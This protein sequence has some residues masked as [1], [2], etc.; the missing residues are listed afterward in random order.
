MNTLET[1]RSTAEFMITVSSHHE[2][3]CLNTIIN[4]YFEIPAHLRTARSHSQHKSKVSE[5][6]TS[7]D[8][9]QTKQRLET[10]P[11]PYKNTNAKTIAFLKP[12]KVGS[13]TVGSLLSMHAYLYN[14]ELSSKKK[15]EKSIYFKNRESSDSC[16]N[17]VETYHP[18]V[19][20]YEDIHR[21]SQ[22]QSADA[23]YCTVPVM[24][25]FVRDPINRLLSGFSHVKRVYKRRPPSLSAYLEKKT[26][27]HL[28]A[29]PP[30]HILSI[31]LSKAM[32]LS[33][34]L[35]MLVSD[36]MEMMDKS[37]MLLS[38]KANMNV[39]DFMYE[40]CSPTQDWSTS[41]CRNHHQNITEP[42]LQLLKSHTIK[43]GEQQFYMKILHR[44]QK[45]TANNLELSNRLA[46]YYSVRQKA[47]DKCTNLAAGYKLAELFLQHDPRLIRETAD[48]KTRIKRWV[49]KGE[50]L[51]SIDPKWVCMQWFCHKAISSN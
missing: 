36:N 29:Q 12:R 23:F 5:Q 8:K 39:C 26:E 17:I 27:F 49:L 22:K 32:N 46:E 24:F 15:W 44:F 13:T 47:L 2:T 6:R 11:Q 19:S 28:T 48:F 9:Y 37:L 45:E 25:M 50:A 42:Q 33:E 10:I 20:F 40:P 38:I 7:T 14:K 4:K 41:K 35:L 16:A 43:S 1:I 34:N 31:N 30:H 21:A 51:H 18:K 3:E